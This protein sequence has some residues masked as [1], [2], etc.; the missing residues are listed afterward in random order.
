MYIISAC[1]I[2]QNC[3]YNGKNNYNKIYEELVKNKKAIPFCPEQAGGLPTP[4]LP[5]EIQGGDGEA[6]IKGIA[7]VKTSDGQD[8]TSKFLKGA[9]EML[10]LARLIDADTAILKSKSPS[11]GC[12]C[13]YNG[14]FNKT[15]KKGRGV[16]AAY[17]KFYG[18]ALIDSDSYIKKK[19]KLK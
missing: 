14:N 19:G 10:N 11:C 18:I 12:D 13:I 1:L 3:K 17:L 9:K 6:V 2:G 5:S 15:L 16:T 4:R 7:K 8:V